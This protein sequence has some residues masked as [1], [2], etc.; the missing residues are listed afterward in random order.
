MND[1]S[2]MV[3]I[4]ADGAASPN[5]GPGGY[6]VIILKNSERV[7]FSGGYR[8][9]TNNRMELCAVIEGLRAVDGTP[10]ITVY[11]DSRYVVDMV[12]GGYAKQWRD[13]GW[14]RNGRER[15]EN[16]DLWGQ[17]LDLCV[18]HNVTFKWV[19]GHNSNPENERCDELAVAARQ[20]GALPPDSVY[21]ASVKPKHEQ[22]CFALLELK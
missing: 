2:S 7:E 3:E 20:G 16:P 13:H 6:G 14:M 8:K 5:P 17:L 10:T 1:E 19:R 22:T 9:T 4:Y 15:A 21:E 18:I 11:S 12:N